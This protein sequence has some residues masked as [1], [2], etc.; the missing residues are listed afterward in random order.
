MWGQSSRFSFMWRQKELKPILIV[1]EKAPVTGT[2][3]S[4]TV[5][6]GALVRLRTGGNRRTSPEARPSDSLK[7]PSVHRKPD[8]A[9]WAPHLERSQGF[10]KDPGTPSILDRLSSPEMLGQ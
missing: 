8:E 4:V 9:Y 10:L 1:S 7:C 3:L 5:A 2:Q 6:G